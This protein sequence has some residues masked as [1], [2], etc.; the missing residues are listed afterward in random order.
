VWIALLIA[1]VRQSVCCPGIFRVLGERSF[2]LWAGGMALSILRE[3]HA[4]MGCEPPVVVPARREVFQQLQQRALLPGAAGIADQ[5][6]GECCA[7]ES[8]GAARRGVRVSVHGGTPPPG[9][10]R[11]KQVE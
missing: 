10:P 7:P 3:R 5:A 9:A 2:D 6:V 11:H 8:Q 1:K 4:V